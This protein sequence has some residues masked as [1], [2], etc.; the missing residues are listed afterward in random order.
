MTDKNNLFIQKAH[1]IHGDKYDYCKVEY[2]NNNTK[3]CIICPIHGEFWQT[4]NHHLSGQGCP[5]CSGNVKKTTEQFIAK[6]KE[7]YGDRYNYSKVKYI[8]AKTKVCIICPTHGEFYIRPDNFIN[9]KKSCPRCS[10]EKRD[11]KQLYKNGQEFI[12]QCKEKYGDKFL[13][14]KIVYNGKRKKMKF[15]IDNEKYIEMFP[16]NFLASNSL[17]KTKKVKLKNIKDKI[18]RQNQFIE[19]AKKKY[20]D[21]Y[22]YSKV[23]YV[24]NNTKV[25]IICPVHGEFYVKP[26]TFISKRYRGCPLCLKENFREKQ[27]ENFIKCAKKIHKNKYDYSK[28]K[29]INAHSKGIIICP[30]HGEF[31][32]TPNMHLSGKGCP[33][34]VG[35]NLSKDELIK[36]YISIHGDKYDYSKFKYINAHS[37]GIVICPVHGE[38]LISHG[39]HVSGEGCPKCRQS[40]LEREVSLLLEKN[41]ISFIQD[42]QFYIFKKQRPDFY[43]TEINTVIECQG[44]QH[45]VCNNYYFGSTKVEERFKKTLDYDIRKNQICKKNNIDIIYFTTKNNICD[46]YLT[47]KKF[48]GIYTEENVFFKK[49]DLLKYLLKKFYNLKY[50]D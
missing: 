46:D 20:N 33:K 10:Q 16:D 12:K 29:Y 18:F 8:N 39:H 38:F 37:K 17:F 50:K 5:K 13:W 32:Q 30:V 25:C 49:D 22:D 28:F 40:F 4:P 41:N 43:I 31:C 23:K 7:I 42:K 1:K 47:N 45:F 2:V 14:D 3:V 44:R 9:L 26:S 6:A 48:G 36:K 11:S 34:C 19:K 27:K 24:N 35:K 21:R 15:Y